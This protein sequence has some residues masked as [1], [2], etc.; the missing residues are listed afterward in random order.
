[1]PRTTHGQSKTREYWVWIKM[2]DRTGNP[3]AHDY[4]R[5]GGAGVTMCPEWRK[6]Y[7]AFVASVGPRPSPSHSIDRIDNARGYEPGNVRWASLLEQ[8][9]NKRTNR[10][11][12]YRSK[13]MTIADAARAAGGRVTRE[14][15]RCRIQNGWPVA[16]AVETPPLFKREPGTRKIIRGE[17]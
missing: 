5:Y 7:E 17:G 15:A 11:V 3:N 13:K 2:K 16:K 6:S 14:L 12:T 4:P 1:M 10:F 8:A 9:N